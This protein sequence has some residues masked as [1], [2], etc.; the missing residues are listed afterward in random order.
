MNRNMYVAVLLGV[1]L[2]ACAPASKITQSSTEKTVEVVTESNSTN[3]IWSRYDTVAAGLHR[4]DENKARDA[5]RH[6]RQTLEFFGLSSGQN[7]IEITPGGGW[8]TELLGPLLRDQGK[9]TTAIIDPNSVT[10]KNA[11]TYYTKSNQSFR[12]K[13]SAAPELYNQVG[14]T[15]FSMAAPNFGQAQ[16]ADLVMTFR[17]VHNWMGSNSEA[18][19]FRGFF[20]VLKPGGVLGVVEHRANSDAQLEYMKKS[21]Y[22]SAEYVKALAKEAGF[23]LVTESEINANPKDTKDYEAGVWT[24]PPNFGLKDKDREKYAAIGES[25]RMTLKFVKPVK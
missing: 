19:M 13:L 14:V 6:P 15:E 5:F 2:V 7:V 25:D 16:S 24:L 23:V 9:L 3:S 4:S 12:D 8:Y 22:V 1:S 10:N 18:L 11:Q 20:E 17:N 21:G